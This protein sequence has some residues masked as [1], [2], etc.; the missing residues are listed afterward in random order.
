V[1]NTSNLL[2]K[3]KDFQCKTLNDK[4]VNL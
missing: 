4:C 2:Y 3:L 1:V